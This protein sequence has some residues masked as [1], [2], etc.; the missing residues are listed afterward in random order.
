MARVLTVEDDTD[1]QFVISFALKKAGHEVKMAGDGLAAMEALAEKL[2][3]VVILDWMMPGLSGPE[4]CRRLREM[5]GGQNVAVLM[6][7]AKSEQDDVTQAFEAG[8]DD[9]MTKPFSPKDLATRVQDLLARVA[10][11]HL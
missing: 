3:D 10:G 9:Y 8:V 11:T 5:P 6:L 1:I 4:V 7:S 2:P